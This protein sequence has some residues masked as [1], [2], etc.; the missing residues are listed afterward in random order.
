MFSRSVLS[1][2]IA[3]VVAISSPSIFAQSNEAAPVEDVLV[4]GIRASMME[5]V[6]IKRNSFQIVDAIVSE[7]IGK[8]PDNNVVEALQRISGV[9]VTDRGSGETSKVAIR[10]LDDVTTTI[11]GRTIFT[12]AARSVSLADIPASLLK[13]VDVYKTRSASNIES[14][15][16]GQLDIKTQRPFDFDGSRVVLAGRAIYQDY[17]DK[18]DPNISALFT[19][20]WQ[21]GVGEFGALVNLSFAETNYRDQSVTAGAMLP[22]VAQPIGSYGHLERIFDT[23]IWQPGLELGLPFAAGSTL[24]FDGVPGEY[25][26]ARDAVFQADIDGERE[27][28]AANISL[29]FAPDERSEYLF[30]VFYNGFHQVASDNGLF[31]FIDA[32]HDLDDKPAPILYPGTNIV[33]ERVVGDTPIFSSGNFSDRKTDSWLYAVGGKWQLTDALTLRS[34]LVYQHSKNDV[35]TSGMR[36]DTRADI[37]VDVNSGGELPAWKVIEQADGGNLQYGDVSYRNRDL[38]DSSLWT[39]GTYYDNKGKYEG[40]AITWSADGKWELEGGFFK[41]LEFGLR[42]DRRSADDSYKNQEGQ[43]AINCSFANYDG[44]Q[45]IN[46]K[47]YDGKSDVPTE[48]FVPNTYWIGANGDLIRGNYANNNGPLRVHPVERFFSIEEDTYNAYIQ[49]SFETELGGRVLDGQIGLRYSG[50]QTDMTFYD[51]ATEGHPRSVDDASTSKV[52]PSIMLRYHLT[53]DLVARV[54]YTETLRRPNFGNLNANTIYRKDTTN[55]G[56][57]TASGGNPDLKPVESKNLDLSLEWYFAPGSSLY[58]TLFTRDIEGFVINYRR[59]IVYENYDYIIDQPQ[60]ASNGELNGLELGLVYFPENLPGILDGFGVQFSYTVLD[61]SQDIPETNSAGEVTGVVTRDMFGISDSSYSAVLAYEKDKLGAR[62]S[63]VWR[64]NFLNNYEAAMFANPLGIYRKAE[65]S[66]DLQISYDITDN[67]SVTL[68]GT[69][70]TN[71][72]YQS[73]YQYPTTHNFGSALYSRT[74]ALGARYSF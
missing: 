37:W 8:F 44:L 59:K 55:I 43:C 30:E 60:N 62:L 56:Y 66:L 20:R 17:A 24:D 29:Q 28:S 39:M 2:S 18:T 35:A 22:F 52:L 71:E 32:W 68:D 31:G 10:G 54:A 4:T 40:E 13:Q 38:T 33:K 23:S 15:I 1:A 74:Y 46:R 53:D 64:D 11:N 21:T 34:E 63:Y 58:G 49:T 73:Y 36:A 51:L 27:R 19:D 67:L 45:H 5:G 50:S 3:S 16:A 47:F 70:L 12:A 57:G 6:D 25:L 61:S 65:K 26:L 7:D 72:V 69:N 48:W 42:F 14:G 41:N 9:Q